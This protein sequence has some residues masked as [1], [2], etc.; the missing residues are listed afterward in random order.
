MFNNAGTQVAGTV[1]ETGIEGF[2]YV[3]DVNLRGVANG[4]NA[5]YPVMKQQGYGHLVQ[6]ASVFGLF[7]AGQGWT[8]GSTP[9][10]AGNWLRAAARRCRSGRPRLP[11]GGQG[12]AV[13]P[14]SLLHREATAEIGAAGTDGLS[15]FKALIGAG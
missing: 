6:T 12:S 9:R 14:L 1:E 10:S 2:N 3:L 5:A 7:P 11:T 4:I 13:C 8:A 15:V